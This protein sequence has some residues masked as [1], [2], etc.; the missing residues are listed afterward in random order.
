MKKI[1]P[2]P[3]YSLGAIRHCVSSGYTFLYANSKL[4][5]TCGARPNL[6]SPGGRD[7]LMAYAEKHIKDCH[8][9]MA[10]K[11]FEVFQ[12]K[13]KKDYLSLEDQL[14]EY[15]DCIIIVLESEGAFAELGAF[16]IKD[17]LAKIIL[18]INDIEFK[19][20]T[21]FIA[22]GPLAKLDKVSDFK[23][24]IFINTKSILTAASEINDRIQKIIKTK[25][26]RLPIKNYEEFI[27][28]KPQIRMFFISD[29]ISLFHP[30]SHHEL[31][32]ILKELFGEKD[33]DISV[34]T[35]LLISL[36]LIKKIKEYYVQSYCG[37]G[38]FFKFQG[39]N[40]VN[41]RAAIVNHYHKYFKSKVHALKGKVLS[42][43]D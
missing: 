8:F 16:S 29:I 11:F 13:Y 43:N 34:D 10:E 23:P 14:A 25:N 32:Q 27:S 18:V 24:S 20:S 31:I 19:K 3:P 37:E 21:S 9:F 39:V 22:L 38:R 36:G 33:F 15:C 30:V 26:M 12:N 17:D 41:A 42:I 40:E 28:L 2:F 5:F 4:I 35:S 7:R 1:D 6:L